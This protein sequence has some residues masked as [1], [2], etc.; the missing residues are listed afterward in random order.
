MLINTVL[1]DK[2]LKGLEDIQSEISQEQKFE[3]VMYDMEAIIILCL[4]SMYDM[5]LCFPKVSQ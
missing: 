5:L 1:L 2:F 3:R 4:Q